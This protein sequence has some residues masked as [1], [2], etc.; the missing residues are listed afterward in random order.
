M[1]SASGLSE[2]LDEASWNILSSVDCASSS[3]ASSVIKSVVESAGYDTS[4]RCF[5]SRVL[6]FVGGQALARVI[7]LLEVLPLC[8]VSPT[9]ARFPSH[10]TSL[11]QHYFLT[12]PMEIIDKT[13]EITIDHANTS[14]C[15]MPHHQRKTVE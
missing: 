10:V 9:I 8:L 11:C 12:L 5:R 1:A 14:F 2:I 7:E 4:L 15:I 13:Y 6:L 3:D